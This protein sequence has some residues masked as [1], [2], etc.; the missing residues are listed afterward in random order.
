MTDLRLETDRLVLRPPAAKDARA[1]I[2]F[3]MSERSQYAGGNVERFNAWRAFTAMLGHWQ[4]RGYGLWA[5]TRKGDDTAMGMVGPF[6]PEGWPET[7]VG[8]VLFD[9]AEG[10]GYAYEAAQKALQDVRDRLGWTNIVHYIAP[11]NTRSIALAQKLG[12][13]LDE[14]A[15]KPK[16]GTPTLVYRQPK[17]GVH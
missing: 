6:Y 16:P 1:A 4:V 11:E 5:V 15:T 14:T 9:G 3:Y 13:Q 2:D 7:E 17:S 12:A 10:H 8:W